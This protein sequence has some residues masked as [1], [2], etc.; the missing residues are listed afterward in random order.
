MSNEANVTPESTEAPTGGTPES[1]D[2]TILD[3]SPEIRVIPEEAPKDTG[4]FSEGMSFKDNWLSDLAK[5]MNTDE[6]S[7][8]TLGKFKDLNSLADGY[9]N[10]E[11]KIGSNPVSLPADDAPQEQWDAFYNKLGRP[12]TPDAYEYAGEK[13]EFTNAMAQ[14]AHEAGLTAKQWAKL[15]ESYDSLASQ[16]IVEQ[17]HTR[18][19]AEAILKQ[20][21][22]IMYG[23]NI[24]KAKAAIEYVSTNLGEDANAIVKKYGNDPSMIKM[25]ALIGDKLV[26]DKTIAPL[27]GSVSSLEEQYNEAR[28]SESYLQGDKT[29]IARVQSLAQRL[30]K[31]RDITNR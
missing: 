11:K 31:A 8:K 2:T 15:A 5:S 13:T 18:E 24:E 26:E 22:N 1:Q 30:L 20:E 19:D 9:I 10:L 25:M 29:A 14:A 7:V 28:K 12:E 4:I 23:T 17:R 21:W 3:G 16:Q 27:E 6:T